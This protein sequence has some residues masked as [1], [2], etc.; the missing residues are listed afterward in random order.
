MYYEVYIE[1]QG[2]DKDEFIRHL[3]NN[4]YNFSEAK[5]NENIIFVFEDEI[6]YVRTIADEHGIEMNVCNI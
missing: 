5:Y 4:G 3:Y 2:T 6:D 1:T